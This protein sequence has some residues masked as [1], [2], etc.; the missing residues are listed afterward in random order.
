MKPTITYEDFEKLELR[1]GR[2]EAATAPEWS[3]KLL[4]FTVNFGPEIG[5]RTI[6]SGVRKWYQPSDFIGR[7]FPFVINLAERKMGEG[8]SQGMMIMA[9]GAEQPVPFP[10]PEGIEAGTVIR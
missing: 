5:Q 10:L 3:N 8:I 6:L 4:E 7:N 2:V 1:V 9:D